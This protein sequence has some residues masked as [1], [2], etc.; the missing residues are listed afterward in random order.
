MKKYCVSIFTVLCSLPA[1]ASVTVVG[2]VLDERGAPLTGAFVMDPNMSGVGG[3]V[4][5]DG[6]IPSDI[7]FSDNITSLQISMLGYETQTVAVNPNNPNIGSIRMQPDTEVLEASVTT[8]CQFTTG[9]DKLYREINSD[10]CYPYACRDAQYEPSGNSVAWYTGGN[11]ICIGSAAS[12][13]P[14]AN[15]C[16]GG[17][18]QSITVYDSCDYVIGKECT[19]TNS[20]GFSSAFYT[21]RN[22]TRTCEIQSCDP[23]YR[24]NTTNN[25]CEYQ[26]GQNCLSE[27]RGNHHAK[28]AT[29]QLDKSDNIVCKISACENNRYQY[30]TASNKCI[31]QQGEPCTPENTSHVKEAKYAYDASSDT[32]RCEIKKC[33]SSDYTPNDAKNQCVQSQGDCTDAAKKRDKNATAGVMRNSICYITDCITGFDPNDAG[34]QCVQKTGTDCTPQYKSHYLTAKWVLDSSNSELICEI[35]TCDSPEYAVENNKCVKQTG[36][37]CTYTPNP[38]NLIDTATLHLING[39]LEC[40]ID[41]CIDEYTPNAAGTACEQSAGE[42]TPTDPNAKTGELKN[43]VCKITECK[44]S[45]YIVDRKNNECDLKAGTNC[46]DTLPARANVATAEWILGPDNEWYCEAKTCISPQGRYTLDE[47]SNTC[48]AAKTGECDVSSVPNATKGEWEWHTIKN[49]YVCT[50]VD[51]TKD[52]V[53]N[54]AGDA[55]TQSS[56]PCTPDD[57]NA[58]AG[59]FRGGTCIVSECK[60]YFTKQDGKC[61]SDVGS[62]CTPENNQHVKSAVWEQQTDGT[63]ACIVKTCDSDRYEIEDNACVDKK[64]T[65]C[66]DDEKPTDANATAFEMKWKNGALLCEITECTKEYLPSDDGQTCVKSEGDCTTEQLAEIEHATA[67]E[68]KRG[69]CRPTDCE[70]GF[71]PDGK[72]CVEIGGKCTTMPENARRAHR[73]YDA[74]SGTEICIID[75]CKSDYVLS[76]DKMSCAKPQLSKEDAQKQIDELQQNADAMREREQSLANRMTG[77]IAIGAM[78]IGG[79]QIG[80]SLAEQNADDAAERDMAAYLATFRCDYGS[81][82]NIQGGETNIQLPGANTLLPLYNEYTTLAADLKTRKE[83]LGMAP[84]I[85]SEVILDAATSGLYDNESLGIT[86]GVYTSISRALMAPGGTDASEWAAQRADTQQQLK[87]GAIV[88]G[89][90]ALVGVAGNV[91]TNYVGKNQPKESSDEITAKYDSKRT[92]LFQKLRPVQEESLRKAIDVAPVVEEDKEQDTSSPIVP[93]LDNLFETTISDWQSACTQQGGTWDAEDITCICPGNAWWNLLDGKCIEI[94]ISAINLNIGTSVLPKLPIAVFFA[95]SLFDS[96]KTTLKS[97]TEMDKTI[98]E[99]R[100]ATSG[101][102]NFKLLIVGYTDTDRILTWKDI[103]TKDKICDNNALGRARAQTVADY[104]KSQWPELPANTITVDTAGEKCAKRTTDAKQKAL[105]RKVAIY[106]AF[107]GEALPTSAEYCS[108]SQSAQ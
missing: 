27:L 13:G 87:T 54:E 18:C 84:G 94:E 23:G 22:N 52:Y 64:G 42:C 105:Y 59:K 26:I 34:T 44:S 66:P 81:G 21:W 69:K 7:P 71:E 50:V 24:H 98:Q 19:P 70:D 100:T 67:G 8:A 83:A 63:L 55:C 65:A 75:K 101:E 20:T 14:C 31:D 17:N 38:N 58:A 91:L 89:A 30:D 92:L 108:S 106:V 43:G 4:E 12:G 90:G 6:T 72:Q 74:A 41:D 1:M 82:L 93:N 86:D 79:M 32:L 97:T 76:P 16:A 11:S 73:E 53:P 103:C 45:D 77:G 5:S 60:P 56:G 107:N 99:L 102:T 85:E 33:D 48:T 80:A 37:D 51:C 47:A 29:W 68:L 15:F 62:K 9:S 35:K 104:I 49:A 10:K 57:P 2:R 39:K 25:T 40:R 28:T 78:G 96:G 95:D 3:Y 61:V 88:A 36:K 46:A